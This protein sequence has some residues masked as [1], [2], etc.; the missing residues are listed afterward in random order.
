MDLITVTIQSRAAVLR[1]PVRAR[2]WDVLARRLSYEANRFTGGGPFGHQRGRSTK[3]VFGRIGRN[4]YFLPAFAVDAV[5][6]DLRGRGYQVRVTTDESVWLGDRREVDWRVL[7]EVR[8]GERRLVAALA[9]CHS[10]LLEATRSAE[11]ARAVE[12][13]CRLHPR[14]R[15]LVAAARKSE[16]RELY[17]LLKPRLGTEVATARNWEWGGANRCLVSTYWVPDVAN[18]ADWDVVV[19][20]DALQVAA[21]SHVPSL[22]R[23]RNKRLFGFVVPGWRAGPAVRLR[24]LSFV[25]PEIYHLGDGQ[26]PGPA[27]RVLALRPPWAAPCPDNVSPLE[28]KRRSYWLNASR[29]DALAAVARAF[30]ARDQPTLWA[31]GLLLG[32]RPAALPRTAR[33]SVTILVESPAHGR[34]LLARLPGWR[35]EARLPGVESSAPGGWEALARPLDG[36]VLTALAAAGWPRLATDV[37]VRADGG[38]GWPLRVAAPAPVSGA[39]A[40]VVDVLDDADGPAAAASRR[41]IAEY[42]DWGWI[43]EHPGGLAAIGRANV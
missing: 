30:R 1:T 25:G 14:A 33:L 29:N 42:A 24:L 18:P 27:V 5:V 17:G 38:A 20:A 23:L 26:G 8:P 28:R 37:L 43:V 4:V 11:V 9:G 40:L 15:V 31:H 22:T 19:F 32:D 12:L 2:V 3:H 6:T 13:L 34:E 36:V 16:V 21:P 7:C 35:L 10:G 39:E 41:R